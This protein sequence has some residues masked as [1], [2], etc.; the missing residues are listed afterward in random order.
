M[1]AS[2]TAH[3][4]QALRD[5]VEGIHTLSLDLAELAESFDPIAAHRLRMMAALA[6][7]IVVST[8]RRIADLAANG[9]GQG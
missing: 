4:Y 3:N 2:T 9:A 5:K 8:E 7:K 1:T 6:R